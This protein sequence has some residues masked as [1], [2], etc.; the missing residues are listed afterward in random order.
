MAH[1]KKA[2]MNKISA[3]TPRRAIHRPILSHFDF[4]RERMMAATKKMI[5]TPGKTSREAIWKKIMVRMLGWRQRLA[6]C[7]QGCHGLSGEHADHRA[8]ASTYASS[9]GPSGFGGSDLTPLFRFNANQTPTAPLKESG[10]RGS[11]ILARA[12]GETTEEQKI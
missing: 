8:V 2:A 4:S 7:F 10:P 5:I 3:V 11:L 9:S 12:A 1:P 6:A